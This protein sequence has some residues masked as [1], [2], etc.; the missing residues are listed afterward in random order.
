MQNLC[1]NVIMPCDEYL[2]VKEHK[3]WKQKVEIRSQ[4]DPFDGLQ[5]LRPVTLSN[6]FRDIL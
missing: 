1:P 6:A 3:N 2:S 4:I 5:I